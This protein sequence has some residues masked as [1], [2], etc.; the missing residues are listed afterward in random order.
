MDTLEK[1]NEKSHCLVWSA[2]DNSGY[3]QA[4]KSVLIPKVMSNCLNLLLGVGGIFS[5]HTVVKKN[6]KKPKKK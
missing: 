2:V 4:N 3:P 5:A 1:I 6:Q